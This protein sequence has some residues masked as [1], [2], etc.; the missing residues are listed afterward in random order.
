MTHSL[1]QRATH[2]GALTTDTA[3][4]GAGIAGISA[5]R[6]LQRRNIPCMVLDRH[7]PASGASGRNAG[8]LMRGAADNYAAAIRDWGRP[9]ARLLWQT[10]EETLAALRA[11]GIEKLPTYRRLPSCLLA[12]T[13]SECDEL[14]QS[15]TLLQEDGF[16]TRW[17]DTPTDSLARSSLP[18][19]G[20]L[21]NPHDAVCNPVDLIHLLASQ[22][23]APILQHQDAIE[24]R[25]HGR[26]IQILL[27]AGQILAKRVII[28]TNAY[29][30]AIL[31]ALKGIIQPNRGQMLAIQAPDIRLDHAYYANHGS[32]YFRPVGHGALIALGGWRKHFAEQERTDV[33]AL[34]DNVQHGLETFATALFGTG[35]H[36]VTRWAGIMAFTPD[37]LPITDAAPLPGHTDPD[38]R[39]WLCAGFNGHGMSLAHR[40]AQHTVAAMLQEE[41]PR[42][43][44]TRFLPPPPQPDDLAPPHQR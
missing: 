27:P 32:E 10:S 14:R 23:N 3:V 12:F 43:P 19:L 42:H 44:L 40:L 17:L 7:A 8:F 38:P 34:N 33:D 2:L 22:L 24:L 39:L 41:P 4:V 20:G 37:G 16:E 9:A 35:H 30:P 21:I 25:A 36:V 15:L 29:T 28:A 5:A 11:R 1:W 6:E 13:E 26:D 31:P 18:P